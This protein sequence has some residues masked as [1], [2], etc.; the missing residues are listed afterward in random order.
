MAVSFIG[1]VSALDQ[2]T[3]PAHAVGDLILIAAYCMDGNGTAPTLP[4]AFTEI[5]H[6]TASDAWLLAYKIATSTSDASG[7]WGA[8]SLVLCSVFR[9][10]DTNQPIGAWAANSGTADA[11]VTY[12]GLTLQTPGGTSWVAAFASSDSA[13]VTLGTAPSGMTRREGFAALL[14]KGASFDTNGTVTSFASRT[15]AATGV[16]AYRTHTIE[17]R[18]T[19]NQGNLSI[20]FAADGVSATAARDNSGTLSKTLAADTISSSAT[21]GR[22]GQLV[23]T[24]AG[25]TL[26]SSGALGKYGQLAEALSGD[27]LSSLGDHQISADLSKTLAADTLSASAT[28]G[29]Y[30]QLAG[31]LAADTLAAVAARPIAASLSASLAADTFASTAHL[32]PFPVLHANLSSTLRSDTISSLAQHPAQDTGEPP[33]WFPDR[34]H[35][36][37]IDVQ[38]EAEI[39]HVLTQYRESPN[40]LFVIRNMLRQVAEAGDSICNLPE[41]F[42]LDHAVGDQ[43]TLIG[44]RLGFPRCH[45]VCVQPPVFGFDCEGGGTFGQPIVGFCEIGSWADCADG[46]IAEICIDDDDIYRRFLLPGAPPL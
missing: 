32:E 42:D 19:P 11:G 1:S 37:D 18:A 22:Y 7:H 23:K 9:G 29:R 25:D 12:P 8:D 15:V 26:S 24:L 30:G 39:N 17:V 41:W 20:T 10:A 40:L 46:G 28:L 4:A 21:L 35:C 34:S 31:T 45:C 36:V 43:L 2:V 44:K 13:T 38:V 6:A 14:H 33:P 3:I 27:T 5:S 16:G